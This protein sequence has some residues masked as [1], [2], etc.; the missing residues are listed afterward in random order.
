ME[1]LKQTRMT[2]NINGSDITFSRSVFLNLLFNLNLTFPYHQ[3]RQ[4]IQV[5]IKCLSKAFQVLVQGILDLSCDTTSLTWPYFLSMLYFSL[6]ASMEILQPDN[7]SSGSKSVLKTWIIIYFWVDKSA[8]SEKSNS[9]S[10][11]LI[12][13]WW[14]WSQVLC[15]IFILVKKRKQFK[16]NIEVKYWNS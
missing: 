14:F 1:K 16:S 4:S 2:W 12:L 11:K 7:C 15:Y 8:T 6:S 13:L 3:M 10:V 5:W 9:A